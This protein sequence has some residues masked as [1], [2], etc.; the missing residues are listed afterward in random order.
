MSVSSRPSMN[1]RLVKKLNSR[2]YSAASMTP[3]CVQRSASTA[4][5]TL[6]GGTHTQ[7]TEDA[8]C[9]PSQPALPP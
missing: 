2:R 1:S 8:K 9:A 6:A 3:A 4:R 7:P 5:C